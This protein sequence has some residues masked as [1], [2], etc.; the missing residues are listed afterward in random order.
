MMGKLMDEQF[1]ANMDRFVAKL[2]SLPANCIVLMADSAL[3]GVSVIFSRYKIDAVPA[4]VYVRG[5]KVTDSSLSEGSARNAAVSGHYVVFGDVSLEYAI[6]E[7]QREAKS[8][9]LKDLSDKIRGAY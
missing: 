4:F 3:R 1:K 7:I 9:Y 8:E 2:N 6:G 5:L